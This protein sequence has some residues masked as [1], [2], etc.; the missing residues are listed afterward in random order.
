MMLFIPITSCVLGPVS[1]SCGR[2]RVVL[3]AVTHEGAQGG[4]SSSRISQELGILLT[5]S[6]LFPCLCLSWEPKQQESRPFALSLLCHR[7][8]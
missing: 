3:I 6:L 8:M 1:H 4:W 7:L 2:A 5:L